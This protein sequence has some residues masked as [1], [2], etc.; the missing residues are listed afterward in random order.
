MDGT[1][2]SWLGPSAP[3]SVASIVSSSWILAGCAK[4]P[5]LQIKYGRYPFCPEGPSGYC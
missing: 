1:S 4:G 3:W 5:T 2:F